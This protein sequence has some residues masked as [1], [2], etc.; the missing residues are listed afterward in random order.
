ME[1]GGN[2]TRWNLQLQLGQEPME[3]LADRPRMDAAPFCEREQ[4]RLG[5]ALL[6]VTLSYVTSDSIGQ[7]GSER[8]ESTIVNLVS[9]MSNVSRTKSTSPTLRLAVSPTRNPKP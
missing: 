9:R 4:R 5:L 7:L 1:P 2:D 8:H 3:R 6:A